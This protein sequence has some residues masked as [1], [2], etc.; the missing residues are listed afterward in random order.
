[1]SSQ[2]RSLEEGQPADIN[3][4]LAYSESTSSALLYLTLEC[5]NVRD[6]HADHAASHI[7]KATG[8]ALTL[9]SLP[10]AA[11]KQQVL[12]PKAIVQHVRPKSERRRRG[13]LLSGDARGSFSLVRFSRFQQQLDLSTLLSGSNSPELANCVFELASIAKSHLEHA[14]QLMAQVPPEARPALTS[15]VLCDRFLDRLERHQFNVFDPSLGLLPTAP[16]G[17]L[18]PAKEMSTAGVTLSGSN[19]GLQP[20]WLRLD[21]LKHKWKGTY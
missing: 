13:A 9:R 10:Y 15:A 4:L 3:A 7:G 8:I 1:M 11:S 5:L 21:L 14:R 2:E 12:I 19:Q 20:M 17:A 18:D 6:V 16:K